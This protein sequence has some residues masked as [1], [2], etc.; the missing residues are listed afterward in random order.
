MPEGELQKLKNQLVSDEGSVDHIYDD[1]NGKLHF[2]VVHYITKKDPEHGQPVYTP[3]SEERINEA[4]EQDI[5]RALKD[6]G[7]WV[8]K[9]KHGVNDCN[10]LPDEVKQILT[11]MMFE[12]GLASMNTF[13]KLRYVTLLFYIL[14][15]D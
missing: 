15:V 12:M 4:F 7:K 11:N 5:N 14:I 6:L 1:G 10:A 9:C 13:K 8:A 2:G 3:V